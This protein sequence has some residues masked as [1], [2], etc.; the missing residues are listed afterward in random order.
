M[1]LDRSSRAS[2][3]QG[4]AGCVRRKEN[5]DR[6]IDTQVPAAIANADR[7]GDSRGEIGLGCEHV[8]KL[9]SMTCRM[10]ANDQ[11]Q[12]GEPVEPG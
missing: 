7:R 8:D 10:L 3:A 4:L 11:R 1:A 9:C 5:L 12:L 2:C 6:I